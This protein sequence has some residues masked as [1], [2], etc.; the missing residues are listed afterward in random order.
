MSGERRAIEHPL[1]IDFSGRLV[2][3]LTFLLQTEYSPT[4]VVERRSDGVITSH[5]PWYS[6]VALELAGIDAV[7]VLYL[8][9]KDNESALLTACLDETVEP[10][11]KLLTGADFG[12]G[13]TKLTALHWPEVYEMLL[14]SNERSARGRL[15]CNVATSAR[16]QWVVADQLRGAQLEYIAN[17]RIR[18]LIVTSLQTFL[19]VS[20]FLV[21]LP[22]V[23]E[24]VGGPDRTSR[25]LNAVAGLLRATSDIGRALQG[26]VHGDELLDLAKAARHAVN[27]LV[28]LKD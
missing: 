23:F 12:D 8:M 3:P 28:D 20:N 5:T 16:V 27:T 15:L 7:A 21:E 2:P 13:L 6:E 14:R 4:G 9:P 22:G 18:D 24:V 1:C 17:E 11:F 25:R 10:F 26:G 19:R